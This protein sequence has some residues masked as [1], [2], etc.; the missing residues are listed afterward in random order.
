[1]VYSF[2][3]KLELSVLGRLVSF[4]SAP[5]DYRNQSLEAVTSTPNSTADSPSKLAV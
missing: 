1:M 2:K 4:V 5:S 3:I